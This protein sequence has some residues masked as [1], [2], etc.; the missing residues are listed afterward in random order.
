VLAALDGTRRWNKGKVKFPAFLF[1]AMRSISSNWAKSY[2][3]EDTPILEADLRRENEEGK[4]FSPLDALQAQDPDREQQAH[5]AQA[6]ERIEAL[7]KDDEQAQKVLMGWDDGLDAP[8][9]RELWNFS[10]KEYNT[11]VRRIRRHIDA[12]GLMPLP[13]TG[14]PNV[15]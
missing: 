11:I 2:K 4:I 3:P 6:L 14:K 13:A 5:A 9:V 12:A 10:Q 8:A 1:G 15:R 7:F